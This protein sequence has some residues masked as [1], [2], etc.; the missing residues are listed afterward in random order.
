[1]RQNPKIPAL[2]I[3]S[4]LLFFFLMLL[5]P[6]CTCEGKL[7]RIRKSCPELLEKDSIVIRDTLYTKKVEKDTIFRFD[8]KDTVIIKEG[9]MTVKY[10]YNTTDST[11]YI[12]GQCDTIRIIREKIIPYDRIVHRDN[13]WSFAKQFWWL[14]LLIILGLLLLYYFRKKT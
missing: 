1:M 4:I 10:F 14:F 13:F 2:L 7:S 6:G 9:N 5:I 11:V 12:K 3:L 8:Q